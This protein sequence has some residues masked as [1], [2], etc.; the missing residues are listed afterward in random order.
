[1]LV[2]TLSSSGSGLEAEITVVLHELYRLCD[3]QLHISVNVDFLVAFHSFFG[4]FNDI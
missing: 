3:D 2:Y 1:M 4:D